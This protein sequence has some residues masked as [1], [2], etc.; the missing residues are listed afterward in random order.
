MP[1]PVGGIWKSFLD[2]I[3]GPPRQVATIALVEGSGRYIATLPGGT[4]L[5]VFGEGA[6]TVGTNVFIRGT[7]IE[8]TASSLTSVTIE[9]Q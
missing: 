9:V 8:G 1:A 2:L 4:S 7:Q 6:Y 3:A 5:P